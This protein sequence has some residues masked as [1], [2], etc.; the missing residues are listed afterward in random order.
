MDQVKEKVLAFVRAQGRP[1][2]VEEM[3]AVLLLP[4]DMVYSAALL[5][6]QEKRLTAVEEHKEVE[7]VPA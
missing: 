4:P 1:V 7:L 6:V 3:A 5:L 2:S